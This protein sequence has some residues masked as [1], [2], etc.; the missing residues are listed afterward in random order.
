MIIEFD[1]CCII[2]YVVSGP[3]YCRR[4]FPPPSDRSFH[5]LRWASDQIYVPG[6]ACSPS[7]SRVPL[8]LPKGDRSEALFLS[9]RLSRI[10][11]RQVGFRL[12]HW[13]EKA[14]VKKVSPHA[15]RHTFA[16]MLYD[17][18][19]EL[20]LVKRALGH[21]HISTTEIYTHVTDDQLLEALETI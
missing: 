10:S 18:T 7:C 3:G 21:R 9:N 4:R 16:T 1:C 12:T 17:K 5:M 2:L 13:L 20:L 14:G 6:K 8:A 19:S 15:L 11:S